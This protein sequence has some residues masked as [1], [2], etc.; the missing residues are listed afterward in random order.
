M[1]TRRVRSREQLQEDFRR[2]IS[3]LL[4]EEG[5]SSE[6]R[7]AGLLLA[8]RAHGL[9]IDPGRVK[10][11]EKMWAACVASRKKTQRKK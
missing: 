3:Q 8:M 7:L 2:L 6:D 11:I 1:P 5:I 9:P 4:S 10:K